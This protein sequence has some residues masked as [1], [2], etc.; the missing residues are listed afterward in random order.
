MLCM[1]R[2]NAFHIAN[3]GK[4]SGLLAASLQAVKSQQDERVKS[5]P[6]TSLKK[7]DGTVNI[8]IKQRQADAKQGCLWQESSCGSD[9]AEKSIWQLIIAS[10]DSWYHH[11]YTETEPPGNIHGLQS[12]NSECVADAVL[13]LILEKYQCTLR[14]LQTCAQGLEGPVCTSWSILFWHNCTGSIH[15]CSCNN[16]VSW[17]F[18][19]Y[20]I[21]DCAFKR[22]LS[23]LVF[24]R[25]L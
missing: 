24:H 7:M 21:K 9:R 4:T 17:N 1:I 12:G 10:V 3:L 6:V 15:V 14:P 8:P 18:Y 5:Q 11:Q 16:Q 2:R 19:D 20:T 22:G 13:G 23:G 25:P